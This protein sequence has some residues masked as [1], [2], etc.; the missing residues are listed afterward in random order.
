MDTTRGRDDDN[1]DDAVTLPRPTIS[2][3]CPCSTTRHHHFIG[4]AKIL[5]TMK[6]G[7]KRRDAKVRIDQNAYWSTNRRSQ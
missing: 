3:V 1:D 6:K 4:V 7:S 2:R 5:F